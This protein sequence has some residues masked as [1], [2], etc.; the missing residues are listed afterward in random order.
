M[1]SILPCVAPSHAVDTTTQT[2]LQRP[3]IAPLVPRCQTWGT[4]S[5]FFSCLYSVRAPS[6]N[7]PQNH[8]TAQ[9]QSTRLSTNNH[10]ATGPLALKT[11]QGWKG[12]VKQFLQELAL[13]KSMQ[14][15]Q[16]DI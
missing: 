7:R 15:I 1:V 8:Q 13:Y 9:W 3:L 5:H 6:M 12:L 2:H 10:R 4:S 14:N 11:K 16:E